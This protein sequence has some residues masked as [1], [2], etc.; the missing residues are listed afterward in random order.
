[1]SPKEGLTTKIFPGRMGF[2]IVF[3]YNGIFN[4]GIQGHQLLL[5]K[6]RMMSD[7]CWDGAEVEGTASSIRGGGSL[8][9]KLTA[10]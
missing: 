5:A 6:V 3:L 8:L 2:I 9:W 7:H 10:V 4:F 1:M